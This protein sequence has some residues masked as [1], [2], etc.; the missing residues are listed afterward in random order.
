MSNYKHNRRRFMQAGVAAVLTT[1][2]GA[3]AAEPLWPAAQGDMPYRELGK[4][5]EK[6]SALCL[7]GYHM[8]LISDEQEAIRLVHAAQDMGI[9]FFDNAWDYHRGGSEE[10]LGKAL[11]GSRRQKA[12]VMTKHHGR[13]KA[14]AMKHLEDSLR[15]LRTD[16]IDLWQFHEVVWPEVPE[17]IFSDGGS[18]EAAVE[19]KKAGKVRYIGFTGHKDPDIHLIMLGKPFDFDTVQM[20]LNPFDPHYRSF[21]KLVLPILTKRRIGVIA[22]KTMGFGHIPLTRAVSH[23]ECIQYALSL[24]VSTV[25]TGCDSLDVLKKNVEA[26]RSF[27]PFS[28]EQVVDILNRTAG[29]AASGVYE[30]YKS[31]NDFNKPL[32]WEEL[33]T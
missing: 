7:G 27:R 19:A 18:I 14:L 26:A 6:V 11:Q 30:P 10:L 31:T 24:P 3:V 25:C 28:R 2:A 17:M 5:G 9:N 15:R 21:E 33:D 22:M 12:F 32:L 20:P 23:Q 4:T 29:R 16:H 13:K 1:G 8:R